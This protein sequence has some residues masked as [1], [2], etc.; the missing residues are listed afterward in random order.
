MGTL[1][2]NIIYGHNQNKGKKHTWW[3]GEGLQNVRSWWRMKLLLMPYSNK[4]H[5][6]TTIISCKILL[7]VS[8][9]P[10]QENSVW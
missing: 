1:R 2:Y 10:Y 9:N 6:S 3:T 7:K 5:V 8:I 4:W